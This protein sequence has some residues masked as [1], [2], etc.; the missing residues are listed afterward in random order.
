MVAKP[1]RLEKTVAAIHD[2]LARFVEGHERS[3]VRIEENDWGHLTVVL[4]SDRFK[5][6]PERDR[7]DL[8]WKHLKEALDPADFGQLS[9]ITVLDGG[10]Y[11]GLIEMDRSINRVGGGHPGYPEDSP[12]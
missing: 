7:D 9:E 1:N 6:V 12:L 3:R 5:G 4:G 2:A 10:E 8:V 11:E